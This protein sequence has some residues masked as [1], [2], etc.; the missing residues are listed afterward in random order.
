MSELTETSTGEL[1]A[2]DHPRLVLPLLVAC[3]TAVQL[4]IFCRNHRIARRD[5]VRIHREENTRGRRIDRPIYLLPG[6]WMGTEPGTIPCCE[7]WGWKMV[8][9]TD[10]QVLNGT[11][12]WQNSWLH[13]GDS[14]PSDRKHGFSHRLEVLTGTGASLLLTA[15]RNPAL[16]GSMLA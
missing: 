11:F 6:W 16:H 1:M 15:R 7:S 13:A 4:D 2:V 10:E 14:S 12:S 3:H 8:S 5:V 9:I